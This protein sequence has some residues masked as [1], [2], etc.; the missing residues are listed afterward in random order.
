MVRTLA[1]RSAVSR[2]KTR[3]GHS[4]NL[5]LVIPQLLLLLCSVVSLALKRPYGELPIKYALYRGKQ[6]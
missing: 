3:S 2:F 4:L 5:F 1:L 6:N